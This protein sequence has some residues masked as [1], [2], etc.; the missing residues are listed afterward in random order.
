[1]SDSVGAAIFLGAGG[2]LTLGTL[3]LTWK[4]AGFR[5][6]ATR[7]VGVVR[8]RRVAPASG[9]DDGE[10]V[11]ITVEYEDLGGTKQRATS[12]IVTGGI[13]VGRA[14]GPATKVFGPPDCEVGDEVPILYDAE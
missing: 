10:T 12:P 5:R 14:P 11:T 7:T 9:A 2:L 1:M 6:R 8:E 13:S 4:E 3:A